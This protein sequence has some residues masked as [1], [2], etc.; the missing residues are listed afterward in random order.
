MCY[1]IPNKLFIYLPIEKYLKYSHSILFCR[2]LKF[3][4]LKHRQNHQYLQIISQYKIHL[5]FNIH[6]QDVQI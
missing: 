2:R 1:K 4:F 3:K 6:T 5:K